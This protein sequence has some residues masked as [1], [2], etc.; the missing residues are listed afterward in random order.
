[1]VQGAAVERRI[2]NVFGARVPVRFEGLAH[3]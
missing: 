1:V 2:K 3:T